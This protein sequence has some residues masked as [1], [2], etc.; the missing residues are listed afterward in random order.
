MAL[1]IEVDAGLAFFVHQHFRDH[2]RRQLWRAPT[3][4][5]R[6]NRLEHIFGQKTEKGICVTHKTGTR[7]NARFHRVKVQALCFVGELQSRSKLALF[8]C[9]VRIVWRLGGPV[10]AGALN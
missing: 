5:V 9:G 1:L 6:R 2:M 10:S 4:D 7:A 3:L 8:R